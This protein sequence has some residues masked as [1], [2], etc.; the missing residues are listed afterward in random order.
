MTYIDLITSQNV[1]ERVGPPSLSDPGSAA[2]G[3]DR[4]KGRTGLNDF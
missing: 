2:A 4:K 1:G 3:G